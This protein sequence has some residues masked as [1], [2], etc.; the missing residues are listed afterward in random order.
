MVEVICWS[1]TADAFPEAP[2][3]NSQ[4]RWKTLAI[5]KNLLKGKRTSDFHRLRTSNLP[6]TRNQIYGLRHTKHTYLQL[7]FIRAIKQVC[8]INLLQAPNSMPAYTRGDP[9]VRKTGRR[10]RKEMVILHP[11]A[12]THSLTNNNIPRSQITL[13]K[14]TMNRNIPLQ[15]P[16][17]PHRP[18]LSF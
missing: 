9:R 5:K 13:R 2:R 15:S 7:Y 17:A 16:K 12:I 18:L 8:Y 10:A 1:T 3:N 4:I 6:E 14:T 11:I